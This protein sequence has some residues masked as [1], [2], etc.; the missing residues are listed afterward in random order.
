MHVQTFFKHWAIAE[1]PF[2]AEEVR[3]DPVYARL[4]DEGTAHPD[5]EKVMGQ[6]DR[7]RATVVFGEKGSGKTALRLMMERRIERYNGERPDHLAWV[8]RY[9]DLNGLLDQLAHRKRTGKVL[10]PEQVLKNLRLEDHMDA[11]LSLAVGRLV[12]LVLGQSQQ[13]GRGNPEKLARRRP[14][15]RRVDLAVLAALY[16][17][18]RSGSFTVRW[19]KLRRALRLGYLPWMNVAVWTGWLCVL[20]ALGVGVG[21]KYTGGGDLLTMLVTGVIGAAGVLLLLGSAWRTTPLWRFTRRITRPIQALEIGS[22]S[23]RERG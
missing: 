2:S 4:L 7:P 21:L 6:P 16:D 18:P 12:D 8:V 10:A 3:D 5:F 20:V 11:I 19:A 15:Q 9:D 13:R 23:C 14:R 17:Q 22:A 1:N